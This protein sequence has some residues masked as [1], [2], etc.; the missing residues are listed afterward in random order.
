M[1]RLAGKKN[2]KNVF[3]NGQREREE[4]PRGKLLKSLQ[5]ERRHW[6]E[7]I[8]LLAAE[9]APRMRKRQHRTIRQRQ[10]ERQW[11]R[12]PLLPGHCN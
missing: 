4:G 10:V 9:V 11:V 7:R 6:P 2:N 12:T 3:R 5:T 1:Y 8:R